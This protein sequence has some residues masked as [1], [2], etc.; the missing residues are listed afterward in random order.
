MK[1]WENIKMHCVFLVLVLV[2][3]FL[4]CE[5]VEATELARASCIYERGDWTY[6]Y[7]IVDNKKGSV[8]VSFNWDYKYQNN[9]MKYIVNSNAA[10][11]DFIDKE[12]NKIVC[13]SQLYFKMTGGGTSS[14]T[15]LGFT[16]FDGAN[17]ET[18]SLSSKS[19]NNNNNLITDGDV[20]L[21]RSCRYNGKDYNDDF[22]STITIEAYSN[23]EFQFNSSNSNYQVQLSPGTSITTND[24]SNSCPSLS[25]SCGG[26]GNYNVCTIDDVNSIPGNSE[27]GEDTETGALYKC[28]Y[29]GQISGKQLV[30]SKSINGWS[31][32]Y[33]DGGTEFISS[34][35]NNSF[36]SSSCEDVFYVT[37]NDNVKI[38]KVEANTIHTESQIST[39]CYGYGNEVEQ[40]CANGNCKITN[41]L[42]G[43][44]STGDDTSNGEGCPWQLRTI[45]VFLKKVVFNTVQL[46]APILLIVVGTID[47][48]K[49]VAS[50]D[51]K[52]NKEAISK[53]IRRCLT[54]VMLFFI[55]TIVTIVMD[56]FTKTDVGEQSDWKKCWQTIK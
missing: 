42:C 54:A 7:D 36:P 33:P 52:G 37:N 32:Q 9:S 17:S 4:F 53:F 31:V 27:S 21:I 28:T 29:K 55:G 48:V 22:V 11:T 41:A 13:P 1:S 15:T 16:N 24:F 6:T 38:I 14:I 2:A 10:A 18:I 20:Q 46:F 3:S 47:L 50:S 43:S 34:S 23:G 35:G 49:A 26:N 45:I 12:N 51:D 56:M 39:L 5:N 30:V 40:F 19:T 25:I 44:S 8:E